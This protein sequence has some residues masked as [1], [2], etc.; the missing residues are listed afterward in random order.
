MSQ[1]GQDG[2]STIPRKADGCA[3]SAGLID[4]QTEIG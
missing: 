4:K 3:V 1:C 2:Q